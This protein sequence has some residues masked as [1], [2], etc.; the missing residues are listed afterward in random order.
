[1][2]ALLF[3]SPLAAAGDPLPSWHAGAAKTAIIAFVTDVTTE[4]GA[5]FVPPEERI[6]VFDN[7]G[8]L[9][10][11]QPFY[12]QLAFA[13]DG[14]KTLAP[15]HPEWRDRDPFRAALAGDIKTVAA[16]GEK[17]LI[18]L[19]MATHAGMTTDEFA[20]VVSEWLKTARH[21]RLGR[22][23]TELVYQPML[24]LLAYLRANGFKTYIVSGG[25][26]EFM[27]PWAEAVY[28]VP[29]EQVIG[30]SIKTVF[31]MRDGTPVLMRLP[32]IDFI[33]DKAGKPVAIHK[34]IGRRPI[35]AFGN[36][37]G[38]LQMLQWVTAAAGRRFGLI[39]RHDDAER[40]Y[41]YDRDSS[42]GRLD[43]ALDAAPAAGWTVV[44]M[45]SDWKQVFP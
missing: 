22:P 31:E 30:S 5:D 28:G 3:T 14:V 12:T 32:E 42:V 23:Y 26:V 8:T 24:E 4:G 44:S 2:A 13:L 45:K 33:D 37:D 43:K 27:R 11:E 6:A 40:E 21:P 36:S 41:A 34:F 19:L 10:V 25:G 16:S 29:P 17:G 15:Q 18:E 39:V 7:D 38:D 20:A 1:M 9:W 35:A